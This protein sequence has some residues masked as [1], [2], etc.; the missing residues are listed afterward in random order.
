MKTTVQKKVSLDSFMYWKMYELFLITEYFCSVLADF[1]E[2][3]QIPQWG[4]WVSKLLIKFV[5]LWIVKSLFKFQ[6]SSI[7]ALF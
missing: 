3:K 6:Q 5:F 7:K 1:L 2:M 4:L